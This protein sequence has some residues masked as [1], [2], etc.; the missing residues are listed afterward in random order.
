M[1]KQEMSQDVAS[2]LWQKALDL[3]RSNKKGNIKKAIKLAQRILD[4]RNDR[5][6]I[7]TQLKT[8]VGDC[9]HLNLEQH[10]KAMVY[11]QSAIEGDN[12]PW[13]S[14]MLGEIY[15]RNKKDYKAAAEILEKTVARGISSAG[16]RDIARDRLAEA[17]QKLAGN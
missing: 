14:I 12:D 9:Y 13:A 4:E 11:Y 10:D 2:E 16:Q 7:S 15:L 3:R 17:R 1:S 8:F 6:P 5:P